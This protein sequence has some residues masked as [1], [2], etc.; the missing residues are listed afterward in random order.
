MQG[1]QATYSWRPEPPRVFDKPKDPNIQI[2]NLKSRWK[3]FQIVSP[4]AS[5]IKPYTGAGFPSRYSQFHW[6]NHW[7]VAQIASSGRSAVAPDRASHTSLSHIYWGLY[8]RM[9]DSMT[10]IMLDGL[11]TKPLTN[12]LQVAKS[13]LSPPKV[14]VKGKGFETKGYDPAQGA[15]ILARDGMEKSSSLQLILEANESSPL[16]DPAIVVKDWGDAN[17]SLKVNGNPATLGKDFRIGHIHRLQGTDLVI[18]L[19]M[20]STHPIRLLLSWSHP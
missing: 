4:A 10:K 16:Y 5:S 6:R 13:W 19:R 15:F 12:L 17:A 9:G 11:T 14:E 7:P 1:K 2:V 18:W 8:S 3:P 20:T